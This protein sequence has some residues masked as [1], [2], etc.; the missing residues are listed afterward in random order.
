MIIVNMIITEDNVNVL[1][2]MGYHGDP[3]PHTPSIFGDRN[4]LWELY[5]R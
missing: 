2:G 3:L 5:A 4:D 1:N